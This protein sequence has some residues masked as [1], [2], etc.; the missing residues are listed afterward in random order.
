MKNTVSATSIGA[1]L[2]LM[3]CLCAWATGGCGR[4]DAS[5]LDDHYEDAQAC[6]QDGESYLDTVVV[7][8][9]L[10]DVRSFNLY[11]Y[12]VVSRDGTAFPIIEVGMSSP[13]GGGRSVA[14]LAKLGRVPEAV[15][16]VDC[17]YRFNIAKSRCVLTSAFARDPGRAG[18]WQPLEDELRLEIQSGS[19]M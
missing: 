2:P 1:V 8:R 5:L 6:I 7:F 3:I 10:E 16:R 17:V 15:D 9:R 4:S 13:E 12:Q 18:G 19:G 11:D 14:F